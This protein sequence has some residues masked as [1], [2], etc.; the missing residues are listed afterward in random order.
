MFPLLSIGRELSLAISILFSHH[1]QKIKEEK[2]QG[3]KPTY[4]TRPQQRLQRA[5]LG[6]RLL[7]VLKLRRQ[8]GLQIPRIK[9]INPRFARWILNSERFT[10]S[11]EFLAHFFLAKRKRMRELVRF[12]AVDLN[13]EGLDAE[14]IP[15]SEER[16][17]FAAQTARFYGVPD[18]CRD[19]VEGE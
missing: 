1:Q 6:V 17:R 9:R 8:H 10:L 3:Q 19:V 14:E 16:C 18:L 4:N 12:Q 15:W 13:P 11:A 7:K 2:T 5:H